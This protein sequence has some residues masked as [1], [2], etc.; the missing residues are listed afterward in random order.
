MKTLIVLTLCVLASIANAQN[1]NS[2]IFVNA[3]GWLGNSTDSSY[4]FVGGLFQTY[5]PPILIRGNSNVPIQKRFNIKPIFPNPTSGAFTAQLPSEF[6]KPERIV[7]LDEQ[8]RTMRDV[9]SE[10][11]ID[12]LNVN[13]K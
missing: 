2:V 8:G 4:G 5:P 11:T 7:L 13:C 12:G 6:G 9:T 3:S 10:V 1:S